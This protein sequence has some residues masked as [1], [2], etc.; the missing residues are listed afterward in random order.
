VEPVPITDLPWI[1]YGIPSGKI[2]ILC[3]LNTARA[4]KNN[5]VLQC[6]EIFIDQVTEV[7]KEMYF[8]RHTV[9]QE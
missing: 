6:K 1:I 8:G 5:L 3:L 7:I 4:F 9:V 2:E